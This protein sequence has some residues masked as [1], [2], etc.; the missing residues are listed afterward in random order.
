[1]AV[2][3]R[4]QAWSG[5][6]IAV[7]RCS[8][9]AG[10]GWTTPFG[11]G[12]RGRWYRDQATARH[13]VRVGCPFPALGRGPRRRDGPGGTRPL[14]RRSSRLESWSD[15]A[16]LVRQVSDPILRP[17]QLHAWRQWPINCGSWRPRSPRPG[18]KACRPSL[19]LARDRCGVHVG[20]PQRRRIWWR[21]IASQL[22]SPILWDHYAMILLL[23]VAYLPVGRKMVG[24]GHPA[25][26]E[27]RAC[28]RHP[29]IVYPIAFFATLAATPVVGIQARTVVA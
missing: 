1:M 28:R 13:P 4:R 20:R 5:R 9:S 19:V 6:A 7:R 11:A 8:R 16:T 21:V 10:A 27:R 15:F 22:L 26:D 14:A 23:P 3:V 18:S 29:P 24:A 2:R 17:P 12:Q 25:G